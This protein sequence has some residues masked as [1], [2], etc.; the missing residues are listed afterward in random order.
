MKQRILVAEDDGDIRSLLKLY[1][2]S[3]GFEVIA[4]GDG[5]AALEAAKAQE[6]DLAIL[7]VMMPKMDGYQL[8]RALR[9]RSDLPGAHALGQKPG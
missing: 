6:P 8:I 1:L 4:A 5:Q 3:E 2:E 9:E 7:D